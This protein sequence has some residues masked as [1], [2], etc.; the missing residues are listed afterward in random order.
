MEFFF[1]YFLT[2]RKNRVVNALR[3]CMS[4]FT[5]FLIHKNVAH[6][7]GKNLLEVFRLL[8]CPS[9]LNGEKKPRRPI[10]MSPTRSLGQNCID[11][12]GR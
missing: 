3:N 5:S 1:H 7:K 10:F 12:I 4:R 11:A 6:F 9:S 8:H 2:V